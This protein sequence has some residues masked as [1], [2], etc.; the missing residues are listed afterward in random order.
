M[1]RAALLL[2]AL[3]LTAPARAADVALPDPTMTPGGIDPAVTLSEICNGTTKKRRPRTTAICD[4]V[5]AAYSIPP[6]DRYHYECDHSI[7]IALGGNSTAANL[8]PQPNVEAE[9]KDRLEVEMQRRACV[10]YRTLTP[11]DAAKVLA[12]EQ[13]E[14]A[15]DWRGA[16]QK[17][18]GD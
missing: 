12:D 18:M 13:R 11:E 1:T 8:W 14:I 2:T 17:Y 15:T 4:Q 16:Y 5:F 9:M 7:P 3:I 10:A 6:A